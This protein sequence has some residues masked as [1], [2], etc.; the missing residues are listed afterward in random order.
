MNK[1]ELKD[2]IA[3]GILKSFGRFCLVV[4]LL[5]LVFGFIGMILFV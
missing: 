2:A 1:D 4:I 3:G 5:T